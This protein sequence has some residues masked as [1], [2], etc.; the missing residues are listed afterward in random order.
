MA[1]FLASL[2][3]FSAALAAFLASRW[4]ASSESMTWEV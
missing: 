2:A 4:A 3:A 1:A